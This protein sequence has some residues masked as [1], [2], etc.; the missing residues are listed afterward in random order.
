MKSSFWKPGAKSWWNL[1]RFVL[2]ILALYYC[3]PAHW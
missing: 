3:Q 2:F 1:A